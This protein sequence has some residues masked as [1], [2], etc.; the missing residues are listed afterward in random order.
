MLLSFNQQTP[1]SNTA[2]PTSTV[3]QEGGGYVDYMN[4][5]IKNLDPAIGNNELF[6]LFRK[7]GRIVSARVMSNPATGQ[8]KGYGFVSYDKQEE[9][10]AALQEMNGKMV[11][12]KAL[13]VAYHEPKKPRQEKQQQQSQQQ[14]Q[15]PLGS[16]SP[17]VNPLQNYMGPIGTPV[18]TSP[19]FQDYTPNASAATAAA[20]G[21]AT[22]IGAPA[23]LSHDTRHSYDMAMPPPPINGERLCQLYV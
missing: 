2:M 16:S 21:P 1:A 15:P 18:R 22:G 7:F 6:N 20:A 3:K 11:M 5:Y 4:L 14:N 13:M 19:H 23:Y 17:L 8:S 9:A 12:S 10:A